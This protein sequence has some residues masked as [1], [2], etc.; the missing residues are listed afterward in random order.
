MI[1]LENPEF[2]FLIKLGMLYFVCPDAWEE[3]CRLPKKRRCVGFSLDEQ[4]KRNCWSRC[5]AMALHLF[6]DALRFPLARPS[7][8]DLLV[9]ALLKLPRETD[10][11]TLLETSYLV[12]PC[13]RDSTCE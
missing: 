7:F 11:P 12:I 8:C 5:P 3:Q 2:F 10:F 6:C 1:T 9:R 13:D 4:Q